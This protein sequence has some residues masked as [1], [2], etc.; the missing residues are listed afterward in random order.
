MSGLSK[1]EFDTIGQLLKLRQQSTSST[2]SPTMDRPKLVDDYSSDDEEAIPLPSHGMSRTVK[3][4]VITKEP[5]IKRKAGRP[6]KVLTEE[7]FAKAKE[8]EMLK[9]QRKAHREAKKV[10]K[11]E[12]AR[13]TQLRVA[14]RAQAAQ[15]KQAEKD[16]KALELLKKRIEIYGKMLADAEAY[17]AKWDL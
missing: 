4:L 15:A 17:R 6:K 3:K 7:E 9:E 12:A 5:I 8:D 1:Q 10:Q 2:A 16:Q 14:A 13:Q 11:F